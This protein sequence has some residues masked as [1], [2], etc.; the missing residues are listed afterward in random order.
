MSRRDTIIIAV[1]V[2]AALLMILFATAIRSGDPKEEKKAVNPNN[3]TLAQVSPA[4]SLDQEDLLNEYIVDVPTVTESRGDSQLAFEDQELPLVPL[5]TLAAPT[6]I[7][8]IPSAISSPPQHIVQLESPKTVSEETF[9]NVTVKKGDVLEKLA[10][11]NNTTVSAIMKANHL[12][13][14]QLKI[15]QVLKMPLKGEKKGSSALNVSSQIEG[16]YYIVKEGDSPWLIA[17]R[18]KINLDDLLRL[19]GLDEQKAKRL[20]PG[21]KL[22]IR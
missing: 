9:V 3:A 21:D 16:D 11:A 14:T 7:Q 4:Q 1:L 22:R 2:N 8:E 17:S 15:G 10:K 18:N 20:R 6:P 19:N 13:S 12:S 5:S